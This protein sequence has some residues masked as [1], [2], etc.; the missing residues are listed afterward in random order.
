M[1]ALSRDVSRNTICASS[2][3]SGRGLRDAGLDEQLD[4]SRDRRERVADLVRDA[5]GEAADRREA[6]L[7]RDRLFHRAQLGEILERDDLSDLHDRSN[8]RAA[9][10]VTPSR[11]ALPL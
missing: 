8:R 4:R 10:S 9:R 7:S 2:F 5:G 11:R 3:A 6:L 1:S